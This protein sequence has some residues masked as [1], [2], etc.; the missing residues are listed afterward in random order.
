MQSTLNIQEK[1]KLT[2]LFINFVREIGIPV[3]DQGEVPVAFLPGVRIDMGGL[4]I[5][6]NRLLHPGDILH[7]A[8]HLAT[9]PYHI[10]RT[11]DGDLPDTD[12]HRGGELMTLAWSYAACLHLQ[13]PPAVVFHE[14][15][16]K[17][18]HQQLIESFEAG[19]YIGLPMLQFHGMAYDEKQAASLQV[20]PF[21]HM[22]NWLCLQEEGA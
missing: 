7:E 3:A 20:L 18:G 9:M 10:R 16:Y 5:D 15:G 2:D 21:P 19:Q 22:V 8:G 1:E 17:G 4:T 12:L 6:R 14:D 11:M 13:V